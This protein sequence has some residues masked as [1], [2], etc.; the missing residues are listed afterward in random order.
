[1]Y[2]TGIFINF[3]VPPMVTLN[4]GPTYTVQEGM[5]RRI[6]CT[7]TGDPLPAVTWFKDSDIIRTDV[8]I[9]TSATNERI[10]TLT[11]RV[12]RLINLHVHL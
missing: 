2:I 4:R 1:M 6:R 8:I 5:T 9:S 12:T 7:A 11:I 3:L 10:S